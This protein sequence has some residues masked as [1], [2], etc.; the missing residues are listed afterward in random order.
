[1]QLRGGLGGKRAGGRVGEVGLGVQVAERVRVVG[2]RKVA[3]VLPADDPVVSVLAV[4][5]A[6]GVVKRLAATAYDLDSV[7]DEEQAGA[8]VELERLLVAVADTAD[9][10]LVWV[11]RMGQQRQPGVRHRA[12]ENSVEV[13]GE[14]LGGAMRRAGDRRSARRR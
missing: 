3:Q 2:A 6:V 7:V 9:A 12:V 11:D 1:V 13:V 8:A 10:E 4:L 5:E 14:R